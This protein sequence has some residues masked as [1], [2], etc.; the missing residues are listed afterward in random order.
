MLKFNA[1]FVYTMIA[2]VK[3]CLSRRFF[4]LIQLKCYWKYFK[5]DEKRIERGAFW[6]IWSNSINR[7]KSF[8]MSTCQNNLIY[9]I[10][11]G[12]CL[13]VCSFPLEI[14]ITESFLFCAPFRIYSAQKTK[15]SECDSNGK[16][17]GHRHKHR[18]KR[19]PDTN[20]IAFQRDCTQH[21]SDVYI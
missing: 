17:Y 15:I 18:H 19:T 3:E 8:D 4:L 10:L 21:R 16:W 20:S 12:F 5:C 11:F 9:F 6:R 2:W 13:A 14:P 1:I 7:Y